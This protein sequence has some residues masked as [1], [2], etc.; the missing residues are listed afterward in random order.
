VAE[1]LRRFGEGDVAL[2][3][4]REDGWLLVELESAAVIAGPVTDLEDRVGAVGGT[5]VATGR[6]LR[7]ELPCA[8]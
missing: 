3:A 7:A 5:L 8:S 6:L 4:R 2:S 1:A